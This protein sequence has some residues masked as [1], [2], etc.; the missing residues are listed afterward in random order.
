MTLDIR[1]LDAAAADFETQLKAALA[2]DELA[3]AGVT[4]RVQEIIADVRSRGDAALLHWTATFDRLS[5][6]SMD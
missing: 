1:K 5:V 6:D 3:D 2:W 4:A